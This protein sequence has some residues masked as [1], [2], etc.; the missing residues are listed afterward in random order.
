M[1]RDDWDGLADWWVG[2]VG[3]DPAYDE[4]VTPLVMRM[5]RSEAAG[6]AIDIGCG[7]GRMMREIA[8]M[9]HRVVGVDIDRGLLTLA[10]DAGPVV[11]CR[12]PQLPLG[13]RVFDMAVISLVLEHVPEYE[14]VFREIGRVVKSGGLLVAVLNHPMFTAP[15][16]A[17]I[18]D[19]TGELL[20]RPGRYFDDGYTEEPAGH[21]TIRFYH[22][23]MSALVNA[24]A[25][26]GFSLEEMIEM[27]PTESQIARSPLLADQRHIPR[28]LGIRWRSISES[29]SR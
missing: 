25:T 5:L 7:E 2:E 27:G 18:F 21:G 1:S 26:A 6:T 28:L 16:S 9:G 8:S 20:W 15:D 14:L 4:V 23:T 24:A 22:R 10:I 17:P 29:E 11:R 12:L 13:E 3:S 19:Q